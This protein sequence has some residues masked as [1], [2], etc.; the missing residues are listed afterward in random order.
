MLCWRVTL[1]DTVYVFHVSS[2]YYICLRG[3][4]RWALYMRGPP[5]MSANWF[6]FA[7]VQTRGIF[8]RL[9]IPG[10]LICTPQLCGCRSHSAAGGMCFAGNA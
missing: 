10:R 9:V 6:Y 3:F 7:A 4:L 1:A 5:Q 2:I 8:K